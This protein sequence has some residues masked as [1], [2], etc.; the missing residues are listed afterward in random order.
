MTTQA[1]DGLAQ[2][3]EAGEDV[4]RVEHISKRFGAVTALVDMNLHLARGEVL[5]LLG[6][7][8]LIAM[9]ANV[10]LTRL[11]ERGRA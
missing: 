9:I 8:I 6:G 1:P 5:G 11:R 4:L 3:A 7:A 10:Q 2:P